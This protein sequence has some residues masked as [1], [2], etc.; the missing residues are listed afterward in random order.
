[1]CRTV[2]IPFLIGLVLFLVVHFVF[3]KVKTLR[4]LFFIAH[5]NLTNPIYML[6][7]IPAWRA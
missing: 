5:Q 2:E 3:I 1:M 4:A 7:Y 6:N